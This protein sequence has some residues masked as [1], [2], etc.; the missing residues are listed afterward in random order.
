MSNHGSLNN[1]KKAKNDEFY[2]SLSCK[3]LSFRLDE[4]NNICDRETSCFYEGG[5]F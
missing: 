2:I 4:G 3:L 1:A 5:A